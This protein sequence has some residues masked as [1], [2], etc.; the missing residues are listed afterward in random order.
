[1][2]TRRCFLWDV[3]VHDGVYGLFQVVPVILEGSVVRVCFKKFVSVDRHVPFDLV[4]VSSRIEQDWSS[5]A[6]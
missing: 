3:T 1:M 6:F 4:C 5:S 2:S